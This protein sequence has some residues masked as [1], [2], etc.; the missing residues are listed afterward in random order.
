[1]AK[2]RG[3]TSKQ[4]PSSSSCKPVSPHHVKE[5]ISLDLPF[6]DDNLTLEALDTLTSE[7]ANLLLTNLDVIRQRLKGKQP[8]QEVESGESVSNHNTVNV[9]NKELTSENKDLSDEKNRMTDLQLPKRNSAEVLNIVNKAKE[10]D[11]DVI[12]PS[13]AEEK[14]DDIEGQQLQKSPDKAVTTAESEKKQ[15]QLVTTRQRS[16]MQKPSAS[17]GQPDHG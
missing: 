14:Q 10:N 8:Q 11:V 2:K 13:Q 3:K 12:Q 17:L 1:M 4:S 16:R 9:E 7:Q 5:A 6:L 15:W